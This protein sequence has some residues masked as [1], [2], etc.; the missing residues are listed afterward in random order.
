MVLEIVSSTEMYIREIKP[1]DG[2]LKSTKHQVLPSDYRHIT[3]PHV[4]WHRFPMVSHLQQ[5]L[6]SG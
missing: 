4:L 6:Q 1:E 2:S 3:S 5:S